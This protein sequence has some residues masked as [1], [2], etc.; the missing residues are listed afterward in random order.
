[1]PI[2][3]LGIFFFLL[4]DLCLFPLLRACYGHTYMP[5]GPR[6]IQKE[7]SKSAHPSGHLLYVYFLRIIVDTHHTCT[8]CA[9]QWTPIILVLS[10]HPIEDTYYTCTFC[11][12]QWTPIIRV[13][14]AHHCGH[15]LYLYFLRIT[16]DTYYTFTFCASQWT[17]IILALSARYSGHLLYL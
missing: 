11:A 6:P 4:F 15:L 2:T 5:Q 13:L 12:S 14:S 17:P 16:V 3:E 7:K 1:M 10:V 8:F 9:S